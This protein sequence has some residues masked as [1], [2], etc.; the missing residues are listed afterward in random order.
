MDKGTTKGKKVFKEMTGNV[1]NI[2][3]TPDFINLDAGFIIETKGLRTPVFSMRFKLF[4]KYLH[5]SDQNLDVYIPSNQK[6][7]NATIESILDRGTFKKQ[8]S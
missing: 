7:V 8:K 5:D 3:Y 2:S 6:E 4:L 1:R